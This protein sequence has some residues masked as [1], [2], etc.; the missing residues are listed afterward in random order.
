[1]H[2]Q[3][4][5]GET[6]HEARERDRLVQQRLVAG[7]QERRHR[8]RGRFLADPVGDGAQDAAQGQDTGDQLRAPAVL[9]DDPVQVPA[10]EADPVV[11]RR[12]RPATMPSA[13]AWRKSSQA[14][15]SAVVSITASFVGALMCN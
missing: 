6:V 2:R 15:R 10:V 5:L 14:L 1:V 9:G 12:A 7:H 13:G 11:E 4:V 3:V 8:D